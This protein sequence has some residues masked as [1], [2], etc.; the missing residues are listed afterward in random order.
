MLEV[1]AILFL[2]SSASVAFEGDDYV[3]ETVERWNV[4]FHVVEVRRTAA[5]VRRN[6]TTPASGTALVA[7]H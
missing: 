3:H 5:R 2:D 7:F 6:F 1:I 4:A